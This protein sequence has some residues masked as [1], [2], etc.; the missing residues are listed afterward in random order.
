[1]KNFVHFQKD[2]GWFL[3]SFE[4][5]KPHQHY[6]LQLSIPVNEP[7]VIQ[8]S[9]NRLESKNAVLIDSNVKHSIHSTEN[10]FLLLLNPAS[11]IGH[12]WKKEVKSP[13][14]EVDNNITRKIQEV[15]RGNKNKLE[16]KEA[17]NHLIK[18]KDCFCDAF[19]HKG[20]D[21]ILKALKFLQ[22]RT[23]EIIALEDA[24]SHVHLSPSRFIHL[25]REEVGISFR[26]AQLWNKLLMAIPLLSNQSITAVAHEVGFSDSAHFSRTFKENFGFGPR[27]FLKLSQFIQV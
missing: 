12:Y 19:V 20:D 18:E 4:Q 15:I 14:Q 5:N 1:M 16:L 10:H 3:G 24:A 27:D 13:F 9:K 23:G 8:V 26:R 22:E 25:F 6:A 7:L 11:T 21:R 17:I 2:F